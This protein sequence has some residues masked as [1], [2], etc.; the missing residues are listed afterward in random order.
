MMRPVAAVAAC[1]VFFTRLP[2]PRGLAPSASLAPALWAVPLVG[3]LVGALA[4]AV[5]V[6]AMAAGLPP[7]S[8]AALALATSLL[9]TGCLHED[10]LADMADGF[11]GGATRERKLEIMRDSRIGTYGAA[12]LV[13]SILLRWSA[14]A[15]LGGTGHAVLAL[16]TAH[17]AARALLPAF[18]RWVPPARPDGRSASAGPPSR[19][20][21]GVTL[22]LGG[23][24]LLPLGIGPAV[25]AM[26][27]L[28][29]WSL[30]L[31]ATCRRQVG[32]QTGAVLGGLEQGAE[33][34]ILLLAAAALR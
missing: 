15:S 1:L 26:A 16:V 33:I 22:V 2:L 12:T 32:G 8:A 13:I 7:T 25:P 3:M 9:L 4:G 14:L 5:Q 31:A 28:A 34:I 29:L 17:G 30:G 6:A 23:L 18:M 27:L 19:K 21:A 10:G 11:G 20:V 24:I